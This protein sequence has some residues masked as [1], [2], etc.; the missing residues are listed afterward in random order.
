MVHHYGNAALKC[1]RADFFGFLRIERDRLFKNHEARL[2]FNRLDAFF[3]MM[4]FVYRN[5]DDVEAGDIFVEFFARGKSK[6]KFFF[7]MMLFYELPPAFKILFVRVGGGN[8]IDSLVIQNCH[9]VARGLLALFVESERK[10]DSSRADNRGNVTIFFHKFYY[11]I[12][13]K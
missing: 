5:R 6:R 13:Q 12:I 2:V 8:Q 10:S 9:R 4:V 1:F 3:K 7:G 11:I